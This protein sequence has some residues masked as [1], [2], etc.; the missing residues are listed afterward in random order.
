ML[1]EGAELAAAESGRGLL[2]E[3]VGAVVGLGAVVAAAY[4]AVASS[5][6]AAVAYAVDVVVVVVLDVAYV[7]VAA[8]ADSDVVVAGST[9]VVETVEIAPILAPKRKPSPDHHRG[10]AVFAV[11]YVVLLVVL[12]FPYR[13]WDPQYPLGTR[14]HH[15]ELLRPFLDIPDFE[16]SVVAVAAAAVDTYAFVAV[17]AAN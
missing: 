11:A 4:V 5:A 1:V 3:I 6:A 7:A 16:H 14:D 17:V 9:V 15:S 13:P 10:I 12:P 8:F 2:V